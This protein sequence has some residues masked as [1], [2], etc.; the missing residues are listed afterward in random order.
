MILNNSSQQA[1]MMMDTKN[2]SLNLSSLSA[3][4]ANH[5]GRDNVAVLQKSGDSSLMLDSYRSGGGGLAIIS[6][7]DE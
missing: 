4:L 6:D 3:G 5:T 7:T 2:L 1:Q